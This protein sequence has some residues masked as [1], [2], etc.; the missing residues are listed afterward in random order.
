MDIADAYLVDLRQLADAMF[1]RRGVLHCDGLVLAAMSA[2]PAATAEEDLARLTGRPVHTVGSEAR[3]AHLGA[4]TTPALPA[5]VTVC[6]IGGGTIDV[7]LPGNAPPTTAAGGG[8][9]LTAAV[10][11]ALSVPH[12][13]AELVKRVPS[14]RIRS[15][16]LV[17]HENG[18][19]S[20]AR[21][22]LPAEVIGRLCAPWHTRMLPIAEP[23]AGELAAQEWRAARL[24]L[25]ERA[26]GRNVER[27]LVHLGVASAAG[28][29]VLSGGGALDDEAV[30]IV[31]TSLRAR[32]AIVGLANVLGRF[33]PRYAVAAGLAR[34]LTERMAERT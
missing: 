27:C 28:I 11:A 22:A 2:L 13:V 34:M 5:G 8:E 33:G 12:R 6:D 10:A 20:F 26:I 3:A 23:F 29:L 24:H 9:L 18:D 21:D 4:A 19:R 15:A 17:E 32:G 14:A 1:A 7:V 25:K 16:F 31:S 30:R